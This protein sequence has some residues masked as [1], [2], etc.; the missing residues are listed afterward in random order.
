[1]LLFIISWKL[2]LVMMASVPIVAVVAVVYGRYVMK[3]RQQL[4]D[5][6]AESTSIAEEA[7]SSMRTVSSSFFLF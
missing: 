3:L 7:I 5:R 4:Q 1:M 6:L 2:T